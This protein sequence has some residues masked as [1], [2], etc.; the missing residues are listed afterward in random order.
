MCGTNCE[1]CRARNRDVCLVHGNS[2]Q[3]LGHR[4]VSI[5]QGDRHMYSDIFYII[6]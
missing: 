5:S 4:S 1:M 6:S 2:S 3:W